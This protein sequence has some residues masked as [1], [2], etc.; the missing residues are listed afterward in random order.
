M[1]WDSQGLLF[2]HNANP[3]QFYVTA[4]LRMY[5]KAEVLENTDHIRT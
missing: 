4:P 3:S 2:T 1:Q 5:N